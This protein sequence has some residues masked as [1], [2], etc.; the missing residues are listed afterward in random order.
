MFLSKD[1]TEFPKEGQVRI[2]SMLS[3]ITKLWEELLHQFLKIEVAKHMPL[4]ENQRGFVKGGSCL[5]NLDDLTRIIEDIKKSKNT[6]VRGIKRPTE[7]PREYLF[8]VDLKKAFD[9]V[10]RAL[11]LNMMHKA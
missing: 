11:L 8:F 2:I 6:R 5:K 7:H 1:E 10:D 4:H 3:A 9:S